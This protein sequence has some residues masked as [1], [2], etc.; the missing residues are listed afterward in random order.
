MTL[1]R[2][3]ARPMLS[4]T[5]VFGGVNALKNADVMALRA[6]PVVDRILPAVERTLGLPFEV[7]AKQLVQ[8]NGIVHVACGAL[9]ATG[10]APR[11]AALALA[12]STVPTTIA[13]H[14]FW[15]E[16][17]P[18]QRSNQRN[19]FLKNV[20]MMGALLLAGV[21]TEGK[22]SLAWRAR[23]KVSKTRKQAAQVETRAAKL[24]SG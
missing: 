18:V 3:I 24:I 23:R 16:S 11:L 21:D 22:P 10:K 15:E 9:L 5:F 20:S 8:T 1:V 19:H 14:R 17:D 12:A 13:G 2:R 6:K 4:S 7:G